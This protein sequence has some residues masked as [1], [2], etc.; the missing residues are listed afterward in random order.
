MSS[1][2]KYNINPTLESIKKHDPNDDKPQIPVSANKI[3]TSQDIGIRFKNIDKM[4][5]VTAIAKD[6]IF[7]DTEIEPGDRVVGVCGCDFMS[8]GDSTYAMQLIA[9][10]PKEVSIVVEKEHTNFDKSKD[11]DSAHNT[12][13]VGTSSHGE[14]KMFPQ[15]PGKKPAAD[16]VDPDDDNLLKLL[17]RSGH[18]GTPQKRKSASSKK[19][20]K[21][22]VGS[23]SKSPKVVKRKST[24]SPGNASTKK[25]TNSEDDNESDNSSIGDFAEDERK[26]E[27]REETA[28]PK[29]PNKLSISKLNQSSNLGRSVS[30]DYEDFDGDFLKV[31]V[32]KESEAQPGLLLEKTEGKFLLTAVPQNEKRIFAGMQVLAINGVV[33]LH[34]ITKAEDLINRSKGRVE[35][36]I[37]FTSPV[38]PESKCPC[39]SR[40]MTPEGKHANGSASRRVIRRKVEEP[41]A[42]GG[43]EMMSVAASEITTKA[44]N[45]APPGMKRVQKIPERPPKYQFDEFDSDSEDENDRKS[46]G[47]R[48]ASTSRYQAN[49][50][51]MVR[52]SKTGKRNKAIGLGLVDHKGGIYVSRVDNDGL[53]GPTPIL[54]GDKVLSVNGRKISALKKATNAL[55]MIEDKE[56][57]SIFTLRPDPDDREYKEVLSLF[58]G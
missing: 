37:D 20:R 10:A 56:S 16:N 22:R 44:K 50:K 54:P 30:F 26:S 39:C 29:S 58:P 48:R 23:V 11:V 43:A 57:A 46:S 31:T 24:K 45:K 27:L 34:T 38:K 41:P 18:L 53:F 15:S 42:I 7:Q 9:K 21:M 17:E 3:F 28:P 14:K 25:P 33:N 1:S 47:P 13:W 19:L 12:A 6:S 52:V 49:D 55:A 5:F 35:L 4:I 51:F 2:F 32:Q 8:Y 40:Q 36:I